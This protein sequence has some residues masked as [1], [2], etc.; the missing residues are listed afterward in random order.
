M[1]YVC[2]ICGY[3]YDEARE[4]VPF[5][6]LPASWKCP[7][8]NA[9]KAA[10]APEARQ[11][12]TPPASTAPAPAAAQ[13]DASAEY[14]KLSPGALA[15]LCSNLARGCEKQY[16]EEEAGLFRQLADYFA[17]IAPAASEA[18]AAQLAALLR[19]DLQKAYPAV[20]A[21]AQAQ[22]DRGTLRAC[23]WGEKVT[24]MLLSLLDQ[25]QED[26]GAFLRDTPIWICTICGFVYV[27]DTPPEICPVYKVPGWKFS[28][29]EGRDAV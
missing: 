28:T 3:V 29:V 5:A 1:R 17:A 10:F 22:G 27:G 18:E 20:R 2:P 8:C 7:V 16:K 21:A 24:R 15:A 25:Y 11:E 6:D 26:G 23:T 12:E 9:A 4:G 14:Q 13:G 19:A